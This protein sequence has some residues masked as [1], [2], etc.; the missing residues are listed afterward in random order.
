V[1]TGLGREEAQSF[2]RPIFPRSRTSKRKEEPLREKREER[3]EREKDGSTYDNAG[4]AVLPAVAVDGTL[5][6]FPRLPALS[7]ARRS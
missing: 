3:R 7:R 4:A 2:P 6:A 5:T 1:G